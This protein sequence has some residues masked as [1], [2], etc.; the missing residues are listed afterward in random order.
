MVTIV[1]K[2]NVRLLTKTLAVVS[3]LA[4][5]SGH[6]LGIGEIRLHSAL[7][8]N[9][10]AE[11]SLTLSG[12]SVSDI[13][14]SLAPPEK[15]D[16]AGVAWSYFLSKIK[17]ETITLS[18][19]STVIRLTSKEAL[20]EPFLDFLLEVSW[21][22]GSLYRE[23]TVLV[24]PPSVYN[25]TA[26]SSVNQS[27]SQSS[28]APNQRQTYASGQISNDEYGPIL[29]NDTLW[30]VA[31]RIIGKDDV[32]VEQMILAI[33]EANPD[34]FYKGNVYALTTGKILKIP[35]RDLVLKLSKNQALVEFNRHTKAWKVRAAPS[36][37]VDT[38]KQKS[39]LNKIEEVV[40][41]KVER[42]VENQ[43]KL[44]APASKAEVEGQ[45]V[46]GSGKDQVNGKQSS[47]KSEVVKGK[48][49]PGLVETL[50]PAL[51]DALP[52]GS[53]QNRLAEL[54]KQLAL[55]QQLINLKDQQLADLQ[56]QLK[57][58]TVVLVPAATTNPTPVA[59]PVVEA[60]SVVKPPVIEQPIQTSQPRI[61]QIQ[62]S[63]QV[64]PETF[65]SYYLK[66]GVAGTAILSLLGWL[67][68]RK[69]KVDEQTNTESMFASST[70]IKVSDDFT[71]VEPKSETSP[72]AVETGM[73]HDLG[74]VG[75]S[76]FLSE[77]TPS[78]FDSFDTDQGEIDP[79]SEADVYLAYGR[80]QQAEELIRQAIK[81]QP[82]RDECKLKLLEIFYAN[83]DKA[84]FESYA[85]EL[86]R[87]GKSADLGFW[88]KAAE[89]GQEICHDSPL[90]SAK[91]H[92]SFGGEQQNNQDIDF[93]LTGMAIGSNKIGQEII[94]SDFE[95]SKS[96][97]ISPANLDFDLNS[98]SI[99]LNEAEPVDLASS[100]EVIDPLESEKNDLDVVFSMSSDGEESD[101]ISSAIQEDVIDFD[102][103]SFSIVEENTGEIS[104]DSSYS[105]APLDLAKK[106]TA[107]KEEQEFESYEFDFSSSNAETIDIDSLDFS[108]LENVDKTAEAVDFSGDKS[109][110]MGDDFNFDFDMSKI[111]SNAFGV[112]DLTDMDELETKLDLAKAYVDMGD[113]VAAI[114]LAREVLEQGT[115]DQKKAAQALLD[116]LG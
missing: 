40:P 97:K 92:D 103:S 13:R 72:A 107:G 28:V 38:A 89:M 109:L 19:G 82:D 31:E 98:F 6:S 20:K 18:N 102:L 53:I 23:F 52:E 74:T 111:S 67:W 100:P 73:T 64:E 34:A 45:A 43:L 2:S 114:D 112:S 46:K 65:D 69:R 51:G 21:P 7:N 81:D 87:A 27:Y 68:W 35:S 85:N 1:K 12:E 91:V 116:E 26:L 8:Q 106:V 90:F 48:S 36:A 16:K 15:F 39:V 5:T 44:T 95:T 9:L 105:N 32:S 37:H 75:E 58:S 83:E 24:D 104:E 59:S 66:V 55:M 4:P 62:S 29:A 99:D 3:L 77:F 80:Y 108:D 42:P 70:M 88:G 60:P 115:D 25:P 57:A 110:D 86:Q 79:I 47:V 113:S 30:S 76:S 49:A 17:F 93:D 94:S 54:E 96:E 10:D 56:S 50:E 78:D 63:P 41:G 22:K 84:A 11:I 61:A 14:V 101:D 33:Y 71:L